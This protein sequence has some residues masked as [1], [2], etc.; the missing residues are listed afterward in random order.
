M[1][2][3]STFRLVRAEDHVVLDVVITDLVPVAVTPT[4]DQ[5][6]PFVL[7]TPPSPP[8]PVNQVGTLRVRFPAQQLVEYATPFGGTRTIQPK[9]ILSPRTEVVVRVPASD[10]GIPL[11]IAGIL[12]AL[13]R[14]PLH[15]AGATGTR[16]A[17]PHRISQR[18]HNTTVRLA[19]LAAPARRNERTELWHSSLFEPTPDPTTPGIAMV[20]DP[21]AKDTNPTQEWKDVVKDD[22]I[23]SAL[24]LERS[25]VLAG[26]TQ[27]SAGVVVPATLNR[28]RLSSLGGWL[29]VR[30]SWP[31]FPEYAHI[32][33]MGRDRQIRVVETGRLFPFGHRAILT[34]DT[35]RDFETTGG[36]GNPTGRAAALTTVNVIAVTTPTVT[37]PIDTQTRANAGWPWE[38]VTIVDPT[39]DPGTAKEPPGGTPPGLSGVRLQR[40]P[41]QPAPTAEVPNPPVGDTPYVFTIT[42]VDRAGQ[43]S[44]FSMPLLWVPDSVA[45]TPANRKSLHALAKTVSTSFTD[46][47]LAGQALA[48]APPT[49]AATTGARAALAA[50]TLSAEAA[51][52][53]TVL[54]TT[55]TTTVNDAGQ[56]VTSEITGRVEALE[57]YANS[58]PQQVALSY[59]QPYVDN[60]FDAANAQGQ[61]FLQ[62]A[63]GTA[64]DLA[65]QAGASAAS[66]A[67]VA[68]PVAGLSRELGALSANLTDG[69]ATE[70]AG[71]IKALGQGDV[72]LS[73]LKGADK[74]LGF[75]PLDALI[76]TTPTLKIADTQKIKTT[77]ENGV[78]TT[79]MFFSVPLLRDEN[80]K[81][82]PLR[83]SYVSLS[84]FRRDPT[85]PHDTTL[86]VDQTTKLE[87]ATGRVT[88][89]SIA[90][91]TS[92]ALK[93][94]ASEAQDDT[95]ALVTVPFTRIVLTSKDGEK[96]EIDVDLGPV[97][98]GGF[99]AFLGALADLIDQA[100][101]NDPPALAVDEN[102]ITSSFEFPIPD[103]AIGVF[104]LENISFGTSLRLPFTG[105]PMSLTLSFARREDPFIVTVAALGGGGYLEIELD[106]GGLKSIAASLEFGARLAIDLIV[107]KASVEAMGGVYAKYIRDVGIDVLAYFRIHGELDVLSLI[108]VSVTFTLSLRYIEQ[109]NFLFGKAELA[110]NV[111]VLFFSETVVVEFERQF[112]GQ[113]A[114][115][116]F[117]ELMAPPNTP[118]PPP[119]DTYCLAY[120]AA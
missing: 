30:G 97:R 119:W 82:K 21:V 63:K 15:V 7:K 81:D 12:A 80:K 68:L 59:A 116:T 10:P 58:G 73:F 110:I 99:L 64:V 5:P 61:L 65:Q 70:I 85:K 90:T 111:T 89:T 106:T 105:D 112:A 14:L 38:S 18:P 3:P 51:K 16:F 83:F 120:A 114:D 56:L 24:R 50:G 6:S 8:A 92:I 60:L 2:V 4:R 9:P 57:R 49:D 76:P 78:A 79:Q 31:E 74:L 109:G 32:I 46:I 44:T 103:V 101:F 13:A 86:T 75:V 104:S 17:F 52:A 22:L 62:L 41:S 27:P 20:F 34:G 115:P 96:P 100:G 108:S 42:A 117:A 55:V 39:S 37:F 95:T 25:T 26:Q 69:T 48:V 11:S 35:A 84:P 118:G 40:V 54:A 1:S 102:G 33:D 23:L 45:D 66:M 28:L 29:D 107:A 47:G 98:F 88:S 87:I 67:S 53:T 71:R 43:T 77:V 19:H 113:N 36:A 93:V 72:D 91:I 94:H